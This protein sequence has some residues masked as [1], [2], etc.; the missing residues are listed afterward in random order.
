MDDV[1]GN[2]GP[3][4]GATAGRWRL[5]EAATP[6]ENDIPFTCTVD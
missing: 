4:K 1:N 5:G 2:T 3:G 6:E